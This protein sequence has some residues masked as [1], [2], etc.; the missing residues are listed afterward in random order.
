M[1][2]LSIVPAGMTMPANGEA[3]PMGTASLARNVRQREQSLQVTGT[4]VAVGSIDAGDRLLLV[5]GDSRVTCQG[6]VVKID[7]T[8]V[9]TVSGRIVGAHAIGSLIAV[10]TEVGLT[11]LTQHEGQW[12]VLDGDGAVPRLSIGINT[13]T[14]H[15]D[16]APYTFEQPYTQWRAPLADADANA[17]AAMLRSAW[18]A[19][20]A[21]AAAEGLHAA[22]MLVRWAVRLHDGTHLWMSEPVRVGDAT[23]ANADRIFAQVTEDSGGFKGTQQTAL[24]Q[25]RYSL[26]ISVEQGIAAP[27]LPLVAAIDV[28]ATDEAQLLSAARSLDYRCLTRATSPREYVLEMGL[29]RRSADAI[30]A[31]LA[32]SPWHLVATAPVDGQAA[33][34]N[35]AAPLEPMTLTNAQCADIGAMSRLDGV[36]ASTSAG[37][38]LYC[39]T[40]S[41]DV[42]VS[43]PG[44]A[45]VEAHCRRVQGATPLA[46]A[47]VTRPLYSGGFGR[48]PVYVFTDDGIYAIHQTVAGTLGEARLVDRTV[49]DGTVAPV[50]GRNAVY[51]IS[52]HGHLCRLEGSRLEVCLRDVAATALAWSEPESE[53][54]M[55]R[56]QGNPLVM[57]PGGR[58]SERTVTAVALYSDPRHAL[59]LAPDGAVLDLERETSAVMPV[60]WQS[61]PVVVDTLLSGRVRRVVWRISGHG[62][63]SLKVTGQRGIM[64]QDRDV[65]LITASG[66][67]DQPLATATMAVPARTV[68]L[69]LQGT[70]TTGTLLLPTTLYL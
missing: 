8:A 40:R 66:D 23:L 13:V 43:E 27:W 42:V 62:D 12:T 57:M 20:G 22:P 10:V 29:S 44:N 45:L 18:Q 7:G 17:L 32:S 11:M 31:Q 24:T 68:R 14:A 9:T 3:A 16:I 67:I 70:A 19:L 69:S 6:R 25:L 48:Y 26:D 37:G 52:R 63:L 64:A 15:A 60:A 59:A 61:H 35:F 5:S 47:V 34:Y 36:V 65:S 2:E 50:E 53:L 28:F 56:Q 1:K 49:I 58:L 39:C 33:A 54:W 46:L 51:V 38:R 41:G 4:P 30:A 21:D 55:L